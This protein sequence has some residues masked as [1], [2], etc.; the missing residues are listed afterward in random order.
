MSLL[1]FIFLIPFFLSFIYLIK[2]RFDLAF[3]N[4][5]LPCLFLLPSYVFR[6]ASPPASA[7]SRRMGPFSFRY[8]TAYRTRP[9]AATKAYGLVGSFSSR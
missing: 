5:Y 6:S 8:R 7:V 3:L 9:L 1:A 4:V 2:G